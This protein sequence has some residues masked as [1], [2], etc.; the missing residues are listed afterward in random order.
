MC[1]SSAQVRHC[2]TRGGR[3]DG[4]S[5]VR[6][7]GMNLSDGARHFTSDPDSAIL[8]AAER[9]DHVIPHATPRANLLQRAHELPCALLPH[10]DIRVDSRDGVQTTSACCNAGLVNETRTP[11][12]RSGASRSERTSVAFPWIVNWVPPLVGLRLPYRATSLNRRAQTGMLDAAI[13]AAPVER[14]LSAED[15]LFLLPFEQ[16]QGAIGFIAVAAGA[17]YG[18]TLSLATRTPLHFVLGVIAVLMMVESR[19]HA[20][21]DVSAR[22]RR[23]RRPSSLAM[24]LPITAAPTVE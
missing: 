2:Q 15:Y 17:I 9:A 5:I 14:K 22:S 6:Y 23:F 21:R 16:R 3:S 8:I 13:A 10:G 11:L 1:S 4:R 18:L 20:S 12:P 7:K 19:L 24:T